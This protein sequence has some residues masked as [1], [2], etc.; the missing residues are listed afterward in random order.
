VDTNLIPARRIFY[1]SDSLFDMD[2]SDT[3]RPGNIQLNFLFQRIDP[4]IRAVLYIENRI[5][6][7]SGIYIPGHEA[8]HEE[9]Y[10]YSDEIKNSN[11]SADRFPPGRIRSYW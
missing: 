9:I 10:S 5:S 6:F 1:K 2:M 4:G 8:E 11:L 7:L 3:Q